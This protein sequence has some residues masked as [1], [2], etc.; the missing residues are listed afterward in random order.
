[1]SGYTAGQKVYASRDGGATWTNYS[2][3]LPNIPANC[4]KYVNQSNEAL[5][6]GM[7]VGVYYT[8]STMSDWVLYNNNLPNVVIDDLDISYS[9]NKIKAATF[10]RGLWETPMWTPTNSVE[11]LNKENETISIFP[12]PTT[13]IVNFNVPISTDKANLIVYNAIGGTIISKEIKLNGNTY[14]LDVSDQAEG[15]YFVNLTIKGTKYK[16]KFV[17]INK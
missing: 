4:I 16:G 15:T 11:E 9:T 10:G 8:D 13:G 7:D 12:S 17:K 5:Y 14:Q 2:G 6:I 3:T 1:M